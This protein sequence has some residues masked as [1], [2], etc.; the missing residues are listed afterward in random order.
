MDSSGEEERAKHGDRKES[1]VEW[2]QETGARGELLY[3]QIKIVC[4]MDLLLF[5]NRLKIKSHKNKFLIN[6]NKCITV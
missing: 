1:H 6:V 2:E 5:I 3:L 4:R